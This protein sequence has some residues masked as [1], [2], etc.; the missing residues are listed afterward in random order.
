MQLALPMFIKLCACVISTARFMFAF[1]LHLL[2]CRVHRLWSF[3]ATFWSGFRTHY[4]QSVPIGSLHGARPLGYLLDGCPVEAGFWTWGS[5][6][7]AI[8]IYI[9]IQN[10]FFKKTSVTSALWD[11]P[12]SL[13]TYHLS[14]SK[15]LK[16]GKSHSMWWSANANSPLHRHTFLL[17]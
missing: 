13:D 8:Y 4:F 7:K 2:V 12:E 1:R 3:L 17:R 6:L 16:L 14:C 11:L 10:L 5:C 15:A 9:F